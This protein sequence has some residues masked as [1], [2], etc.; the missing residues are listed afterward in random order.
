MVWCKQN[1]NIGA[2][3][4]ST[5]LDELFLKTDMEIWRLG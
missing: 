4:T 1:L 3:K 2:S 5:S